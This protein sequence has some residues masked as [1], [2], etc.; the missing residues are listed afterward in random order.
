MFIFSFNFYL[1]SDTHTYINSLLIYHAKPQKA[2]RE[3]EIMLI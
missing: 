2:D 3:P 1:N